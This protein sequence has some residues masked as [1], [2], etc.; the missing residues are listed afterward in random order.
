M[1]K[2]VP[3]LILLF[4]FGACQAG[5]MPEATPAASTETVPP[6]ATRDWF[7]RTPSPVSTATVDLIATQILPTAELSA[8]AAGK[9]LIEKP[10]DT[11]NW[12]VLAPLGGRM[13]LDG[14]TLSMAAESQKVDIEANSKIVLPSQFYMEVRVDLSTCTE[15]DI[16]GLSFWRGSNVGTFV[17]DFNCRGQMRFRNLQEGGG[18]LLRDWSGVRKLA[19]LAP[20]VNRIGIWAIADRVDIFVNEQFQY[21]IQSKASSGGGLSLYLNSAG[22]GSSSLSFSELGIF[23]P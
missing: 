18:R 23:E 5:Q 22:K 19:P 13:S 6:P 11:Q 10:F 14:G 17:L 20:A 12:Y 7:P 1:R 16:Y 2:W 4:I 15:G 3:F 8:P 21:E 9:V